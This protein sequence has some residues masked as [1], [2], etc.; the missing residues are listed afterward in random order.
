[1][2]GLIDLLGVY[3][4]FCRISCHVLYHPNSLS[5]VVGF[6]HEE[7]QENESTA[8]EDRWPVEDPTV[9]LSIVD[10]TAYNRGEE[11][12]AGDGEGIDGHEST[13][14]MSEKYVC[15]G[16]LRKRLCGR[17]EESTKNIF[18]D[19]LAVPLCLSTPY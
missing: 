11:I 16:Y 5:I 10:E 3:N 4:G 8:T 13:P 6:F 12:A 7:E 9:P 1:M 15:H 2:R 19:P 18:R 14:L 17:S